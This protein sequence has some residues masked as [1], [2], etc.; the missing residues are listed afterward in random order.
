M[1][2]IYA[3]VVKY[4]WETWD[5]KEFIHLPKDLSRINK[6]KDSI[7]TLT[8]I[9][10]AID[11]IEEETGIHWDDAPEE[12]IKAANKKLKELKISK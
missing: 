6:L 4:L 3:H 10:N 12:A 2:T 11:R 1:E 5:Q 8:Y 9:T 7:D